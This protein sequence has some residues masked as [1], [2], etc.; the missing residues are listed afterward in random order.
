MPKQRSD[1]TYSDKQTAQRSY[2]VIKRTLNTRRS[3]FRELQ[4]NAAY[5]S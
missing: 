4:L 5:G 3:R 2:E 1:D